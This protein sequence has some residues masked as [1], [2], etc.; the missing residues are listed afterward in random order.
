V[1]CDDHQ[2]LLDETTCV[3]CPTGYWPVQNM[4]GCM[5]LQLQVMEWG[6]P[7][8]IIPAVLSLLGLLATVFT[9]LVFIHYRE[10]PVVK[11]AGRELS[12]LLLAGCVVCYASAIVLLAKPALV[13]CV[14][15]RLTVGCGF[16]IIYSALLTKTNRIYRIFNSARKTTRRPVYISP[17]SQ[18]VIA[19]LLAAVQLG[20]F[21]VWILLEKPGTRTS[22]P[23]PNNRAYVVL[24]CTAKES[25]ILM[26]LSYNMLLIIACTIYAIM[27]RNIPS[28]FNES[29][30]IGFTMYT[31]CIVWLSFVPI[32]FG[33]QTSFQVSERF[34]SF[35][36]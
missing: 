16:A 24:K 36:A 30:L 4:T 3:D 7:F 1:K 26:S 25:S 22:V 18:L 27:T 21:I 17:K 19:S 13:T 11:A 2:Y 20:V 34:F 35:E 12:F 28:S 23:D 32:F 10:T 29:K 14:M 6:S 5:K 8:A 15:Q 31:T 33:L 9:I